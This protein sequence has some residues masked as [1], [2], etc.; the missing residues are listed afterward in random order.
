[1]RQRK[2]I[3]DWRMQPPGNSGRQGAENKGNPGLD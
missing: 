2:G 3:G 1:M